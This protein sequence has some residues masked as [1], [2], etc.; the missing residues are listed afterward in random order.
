MLYPLSYSRGTGA[1]DGD[2]CRQPARSAD[3]T[4]GVI[5]GVTASAS[6]RSAKSNSRCPTARAP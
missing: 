1:C 3:I 5:A 2:D 6:S 4:A